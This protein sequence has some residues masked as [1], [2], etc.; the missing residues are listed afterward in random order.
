MFA[1]A[2]YV[3]GHGIHLTANMLKHPVEDFMNAHP[4]VVAAHPDITNVYDYFRTTWEHEA[5]H[6]L[7]ATGAIL[8]SFNQAWIYRSSQHRELTNKE[9]VLCK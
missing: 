1:A 8:L 4:D 7:Y 9:L 6:Y 2:L 3:E 5:G